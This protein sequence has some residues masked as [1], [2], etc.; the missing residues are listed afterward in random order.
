MMQ[1]GKTCLSTLTKFKQ[2]VSSEQPWRLYIGGIFRSNAELR[3]WIWVL[4]KIILP[5]I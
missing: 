4:V 3:I 1:F 5:F 2:S